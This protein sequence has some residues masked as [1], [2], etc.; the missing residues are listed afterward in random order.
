MTASAG[1]AVDSLW[2]APLLLPADTA[3]AQQTGGA[4][5]CGIVYIPGPMTEAEPHHPPFPGESWVMSGLLAVVVIICMR[6]R[7]NRKYISA[8]V[9][10]LTD[11][12]ERHNAFDDTVRE[13]S[14]LVLLNILWSLSAGVL[15]YRLLC[16]SFPQ[17]IEAGPGSMG[18]PALY[19]SPLACAGIC[20]GLTLLYTMAMTLAYSVV[21]NVFSDSVRTSMWVKGFLAS[22][23]LGSVAVS[24]LAL[25]AMVYAGWSVPILWIGAGVFLLTKLIFIIKG[26]R[27]F[28]T[29]S[30]SWVLF[31]CY[32]C[33][34][35]IVPLILLYISALTICSLL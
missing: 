24:L 6:V 30:A 2:H 21:G 31:L 4:P 10:D 9:R 19:A 35:E 29:R 17:G 20:M 32:L 15:L 12:R 18:I 22:Q 28:F 33:S 1:S 5:D 16:V 25:L 26:F 7:T 27:I 13:T 3:R 11:V 34:L 14:F 23:G 8:L